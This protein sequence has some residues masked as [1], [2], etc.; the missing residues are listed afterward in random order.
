[1]EHGSQVTPKSPPTCIHFAQGYCSFGRA[2]KFNHSEPKFHFSPYHRPNPFAGPPNRGT[3]VPPPSPSQPSSGLPTL[4]AADI[5]GSINSNATLARLSKLQYLEQY[6]PLSW[7][8]TPCR[9]FTKNNGRCPLGDN[10]GFIHDLSLPSAPT[11]PGQ[12]SAH[13]WDHVASHSGCTTPK[14]G[15]FHPQDTTPYRKYTPCSAWPAC[16]SGPRCH[17]KHPE[18]LRPKGAA[19]P[20]P[21]QFWAAG[22]TY[23]NTSATMAE[24]PFQGQSPV[25][26]TGAVNVQR[27]QRP[28]HARRITV[29]TL[30]V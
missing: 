15:H 25:L 11:A 7:K 13:C 19:S 6:K 22:T 10:C 12:S 27:P 16:S 21:I 5:S 24:R 28:T 18:P 29:S 1:M 9:H 20:V 8:T 23:F 14:C 17:F 2:C 30:K 26:N 3:L 4:S